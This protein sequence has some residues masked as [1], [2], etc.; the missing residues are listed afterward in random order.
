MAR[1][2]RG[3]LALAAAFVLLHLVFRPLLVE[4]PGAPDLL[5]GGLLLAALRMRSAAAAGLGFG[6]GLLEGSMALEAL[7]YTMIVYTAAGW[8]AAR[9]RDLIFTDA[10]VFLPLYLFAGTWLVQAAIALG[11][12]PPAPVRDLVLLAPVSAAL[13]TAVCWAGMRLVAPY[14]T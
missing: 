9:A 1:A 13:T 14:A 10:R 11:S 6:L 7:G 8:A 3:Q 4:W 12:G 2:G 5:V